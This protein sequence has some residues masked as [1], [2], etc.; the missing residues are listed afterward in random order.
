M[1]Q[2]TNYFFAN[3]EKFSGK[4]ALI[5]DSVKFTYTDLADGIELLE[6]FI[7][8]LDLVNN[9]SLIGFYGSTSF[10]SIL[11]IFA[12]AKLNYSLMPV[13]VDLS[14]WQVCEMLEQLNIEFLVIDG[15]EPNSKLLLQLGNEVAQFKS[16]KFIKILRKSKSDQNL[17]NEAFLVTTSSGSTGSPKPIIYSQKNKIDRWLQSQSIYGVNE[18][19][20]IMCASPLYHSLGLRLI[21]LPLLTGATLINLKSFTREKW[22]EAVQKEKITFTIAVSTHLN[23]LK[24]DLLEIDSKVKSLRALVSSSAGLNS[25][26]KAQL[27]KTRNFEFFEQYGASEVAT[28]SNCSEETFK[29]FPNSVGKICSNVNVH[30]ESLDVKSKVGEIVVESPLSCLGT[31]KHGKFYEMQGKPFKTSDLGQLK[32]DI[33]FFRGRSQDVIKIGGQNVFFRDVQQVFLNHPKVNFVE[34]VEVDN[35][36]LESGIFVFIEPNDMSL[37][38]NELWEYSRLYLA[39]FQHPLAIK[40]LSKMPLLA[41]GKIDKNYLRNMVSRENTF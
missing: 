9:R 35:A 36:L 33:L 30:L 24:K 19:D 38:E 29:Q 41:N 1:P 32:A 3:V 27:F 13:N 7:A 5:E 31:I 11:L 8:K 39:K 26:F 15:R 6:R 18:N 20:I 16:L 25:D 22:L 2:I 10:E 4:T 21:F 23:F 17:P 12:S 14:V 40:V 34:I 37:S 28:V